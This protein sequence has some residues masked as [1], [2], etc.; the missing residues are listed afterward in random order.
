MSETLSERALILAPHGRDED[1]AAAMLREAGLR[2]DICPA[3]PALVDA[4]EQGAGF[5]VLTE[6]ALRTADL[7]PLSNWIQAQPEWSDFPFVLLTVRGGG[8]ERNPGAARF[9]RILGNATFVERPFHPTTLVSLAEAALRGRRRQYEARLRLD[10]LRESETRLTE[11]RQ[12]LLG[13]N[14]TL[15]ERVAAAIDER[16]QVQSQLR[17][18]QKMDAIGQL[19]GGVAHDFNNLLTP[20]MGALDMLRHRFASEDR[21][22]RTIGMA[23]QATARAATLVQRLLA[24]ARRQDLQPRPVDVGALLAGMEEL[25]RRSIG[26]QVEVRI[27]A[28]LGLPAAHVDPNQLELAIL[29]LAIN[30]RDAMP[31]GGII[32]ISVSEQRLPRSVAGLAAGHYLSVCVIDQGNGMDGETLQRATEPFFSTKGLGKGTGLGLSMVHGLAAQS[33]GALRLDSRIGHGTSAEIWLPAALEAA[34]VAAA[35]GAGNLMAHSGG[36]LLLVD[37]EDLVRMGTAEML[38]ELGYQ[39]LQ[40]DS[41][42][43]A[44]DIL[45]DRRER[46]SAMVT[47]FLMPGMNGATLAKEAR[48]LVPELPVL[49]VTGYLNTGDCAA[50]D[51]PRLAKPFRQADLAEH[52]ARLLSGEAATLISPELA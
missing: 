31:Q 10:A 40:A 38:Q 4:L 28:P 36:T 48:R 50:G 24:F 42:A 45:R 8:L 39:V 20:I 18:A 34:A 3:L 16:E 6:E 17:H 7:H 22:Q 9:L 12:A 13:L 21:A 25:V 47:D 37:D 1:V 46:I 26:A 19:T 32:T 5:A 44:L 35:P 15:E 43:E 49:V 23:L 27:D 33:G 2:A 51:L 52:V 11:S 41:G 29:N 30:A 14:A